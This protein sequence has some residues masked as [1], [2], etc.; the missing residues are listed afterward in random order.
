MR[1][2]NSDTLAPELIAHIETDEEDEHA[3]TVTRPKKEPFFAKCAIW[4]H[5]TDNYIVWMYKGKRY[6]KHIVSD[7][8]LEE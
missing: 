3:Y 7:D 8:D 6:V 5:K 4:L 1:A 2:L